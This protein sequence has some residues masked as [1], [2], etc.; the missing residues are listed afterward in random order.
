MLVHWRPVRGLFSI[1]VNA[2]EDPLAAQILDRQ[3][4]DDQLIHGAQSVKLA[5]LR[6]T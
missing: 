2:H 5:T 1:R 3:L 6:L 4:I